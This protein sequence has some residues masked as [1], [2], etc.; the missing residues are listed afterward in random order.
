MFN[1]YQLIKVS[2]MSSF[3]LEKPILVC[4]VEENPVYLEVRVF[5]LFFFFF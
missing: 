3:Q 2:D 4:K 1:Q 5:H